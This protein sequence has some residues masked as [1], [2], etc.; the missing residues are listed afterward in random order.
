MSVSTQ[1][2]D[3]VTIGVGLHPQHERIVG[4]AQ[5]PRALEGDGGLAGGVEQA[6]ERSRLEHERAVVF[7]FVDR[8]VEVALVSVSTGERAEPRRRRPPAAALPE[9]KLLTCHFPRRV[10]IW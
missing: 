2:L 1:E 8:L 7:V 4:E 6:R 3:R 9:S 10:S 5:A